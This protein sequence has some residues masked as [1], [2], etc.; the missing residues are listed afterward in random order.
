MIK[1][2]SISLLVMKKDKKIK[3]LDEWLTR[4]QNHELD[5][6]NESAYKDYEDVIIQNDFDHILTI[7]N[8]TGKFEYKNN[9]I[10]DTILN[11]LK[12]MS[13]DQIS[14]ELDLH[15]ETVKDSIFRLNDFFS[16][17]YT[18]DI[19]FIKVICGKGLNSSDGI[20]RIKIT[21][22]AFIKK[23]FIVNAA[24]TARDNEGGIGILKIKIK[25]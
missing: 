14:H 1:I 9:G 11:K 2:H 13:I 25:K 17:A 15:G 8:N 21:T 16:Y 6:H 19:E 5:D 22:Q 4:N 10:Q 18:H 20:P 3:E 24:C 7:D 23:S 12:R